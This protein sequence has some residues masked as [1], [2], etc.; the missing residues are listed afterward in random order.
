MTPLL[1]TNWWSLV[2]R[3]VLAI[4]VGLVAFLFP[5]ITLGALVILFGVYAL[6]DGIFGIAGALR[7]SHAHDRWGWLLFEGISGIV[8]AAVTIFW[9]GI[10]A[11]ALVYLIG[12]WALVTGIL[13]IASAIQ[14]RHYVP[15]EWILILSGLASIVFGVFVL[16]VPL[17]GAVAIALCVGVYAVF[18]GVLMVTL[19][20]RLRGR[21]RSVGMGSSIPLP[22]H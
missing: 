11:L 3:G 18:F 19:G 2:V 16:A 20:I 7:A 13:E 5:G 4:V 21:I 15:G 14:L 8:A 10:T 6:L 17:A 1:A 9:P 12:A 22:T